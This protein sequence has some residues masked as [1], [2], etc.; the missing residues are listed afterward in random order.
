MESGSY[1]ACNLCDITIKRSVSELKGPPLLHFNI[2]KMNYRIEQNKTVFYISMLPELLF[3]FVCYVTKEETTGY[4]VT[5]FVSCAHY[6]HTY[7]S[8][9][10]LG[11]ILI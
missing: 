4:N 11:C 2:G 5:L 7:L 6:L 9:L 8:L 10:D 3:R 1:G